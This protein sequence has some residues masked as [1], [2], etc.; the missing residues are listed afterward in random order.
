MC[1][2]FMKIILKIMSGISNKDVIS[3]QRI[4]HIW[5]IGGSTYKRKQ[6]QEIY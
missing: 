5:R 4:G 6:G 2:Y 1:R 3:S